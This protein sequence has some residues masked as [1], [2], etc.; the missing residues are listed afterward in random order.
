MMLLRH[1]SYAIKN[2]LKAPKP[3]LLGALGRNTP[4]MGGISCLSLVIYA[5]RAP[6]E[7]CCYGIDL[8]AF[9]VK[10]NQ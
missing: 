3:P 9:I 2:Q 10:L 8:G 6:I 1:L 4:D 5:I 7:V